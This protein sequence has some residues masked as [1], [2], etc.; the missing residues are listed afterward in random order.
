M[1]RLLHGLVVG[2]PRVS[3]LLDGWIQEA[4]GVD[5]AYGR[6]TI[7][8]NSLVWRYGLFVAVRSG[9]ILGDPNRNWR[10]RQLPRRR[11]GYRWTPSWWT[12]SRP[13]YLES[14]LRGTCPCTALAH[15]DLDARTLLVH[16]QAGHIRPTIAGCASAGPNWSL[17]H[18]CS[19]VGPV[20][21]ATQSIS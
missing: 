3:S 6:R 12:F 19:S 5:L 4:A 8:L 14:L 7:H 17:V 13:R 20:D 9:W 16:P 15:S 21:R 18:R 1:D 11:T 2:V 10:A